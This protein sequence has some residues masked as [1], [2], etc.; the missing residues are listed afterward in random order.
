MSCIFLLLFAPVLLPGQSTPP[1]VALEQA[2]LC[3]QSEEYP[4]ARELF[5]EALPY[6]IA[7]GDYRR[8]AYIYLWLS[9]ASYYAR[10]IQ[11]AIEEAEY[12][13]LLAE[14]CLDPDTLSFYCTILQ[15]LGVF[16][17]A[18]SNFEK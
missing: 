4:A 2:G 1:E 3:I 15:N 7:K 11:Q 18:L 5:L 16:H 8:Q 17:S 9:E 12:S 13:L 6:Y 14:S 10:D